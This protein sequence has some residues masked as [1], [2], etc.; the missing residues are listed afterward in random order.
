MVGVPVLALAGIVTSVVGCLPGRQIMRGAELCS[1]RPPVHHPHSRDWRAGPG[2]HTDGGRRSLRGR[3]YRCGRT[4]GSGTSGA[5]R[6]SGSGRSTL[7]EA[8]H[9]SRLQEVGWV[10]DWR[11]N[12]VASRFQPP[13]QPSSEA[14]QH[15]P[16]C[17][18]W[19]VA[20][21]ESTESAIH[22]DYAGRYVRM[23]GSAILS[24]GGQQERCRSI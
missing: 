17:Q 8:A 14:L 3:E 2:K 21:Q 20:G 19:P 23:L 16:V 24:S 9:P 10:G 7:T 15:W 1:R 13:T 11:G 5:V 12:A 18:G 4:D 6:W 22:D